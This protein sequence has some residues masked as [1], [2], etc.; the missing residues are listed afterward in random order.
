MQRRVRTRLGSHI[1][2]EEPLNPMAN[3]AHSVDAPIARLFHIVHPWRRATD[4]HR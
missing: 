1:S 2:A 4:A 3:K